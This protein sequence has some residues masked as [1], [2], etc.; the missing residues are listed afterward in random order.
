MGKKTFLLF[1]VLVLCLVIISCSS[2]LYAEQT[3]LLA[4]EDSSLK[5]VGAFMIKLNAERLADKLRSEGFEV[6]IR[7]DITQDNRA[8]YRVFAGEKQ[9]PS[10]V[11]RPSSAPDQV[12]A[13]MIKLNAERLADKLRSEGFEVEIREGIT[14]DNRAI[15]RVFAKESS[16]PTSEIASAEMVR[17]ETLPEHL[18]LTEEPAEAGEVLEKPDAVSKEALSS[19]ERK[20]VAAFK[21]FRSKNDAEA[22][23]QELREDGFKVEIHEPQTKDR[24]GLFT[25]F[26]EKPLEKLEMPE[27]FVAGKEAIK[28]DAVLEEEIPAAVVKPSEE[29]YKPAAVAEI[30]TTTAE[31]TSAAASAETIQQ[32]N[33]PEHMPPAKEQSEAEEVLEKPDTLSQDTLSSQKGRQIAAYKN[34][35][36][37]KDAEA[38]AEELREKGF[39]VETREIQTKDNGAIYTVFAKVPRMEVAIPEYSVKGQEAHKREVISDRERPA[40][41]VKPAEETREPVEVAAVATE[42][43]LKASEEMIHVE[44]TPAAV[45]KP[46]EETRETVEI[47]AVAAEED[48]KTAEA[49]GSREEGPV[50]QQRSGEEMKEPS[51]P[52]VLYSEIPQEETPPEEPAMEIETTEKERVTAADVY[53]KRGGYLHPFLSITGYYTDNVFNTPDNEDSDFVTVLSPGI[54]LSVPRIKQKLVNI[55]TSTIAPGGYK[56]SRS[57]ESFFR[58]YQVYLLYAA[59]FELF[60]KYHSE[61]FF[62]HR[63]EGL[64]QYN[65]RGGLTFE[66][67]DQFLYSHDIRG[68]GISDE[69]DK[70]YSNLA[71]VRLRFDPGRKLWFMADYANFVVDY[72]DPINDFRHRNDHALSGYVFYKLQPKTSAFFQ[73]QYIDVNYTN[74][75]LSNS[76]EHNMYGGLAWDITAK[77]Q[78]SIKAGYGTKDFADPSIKN[79]DNFILEAQLNHKFTPKTSVTLNAWR[80]TFETN[81]STTDYIL[82]HGIEFGY[83]QQFTGRLMGNVRLSYIND[84]YKGDLTYDGVT[85]ERKDDYYTGTIGLYYKFM[86]WLAS[87]IG[88]TYT[89]RNSNFPE[90]EYTNN[91]FFFNLTGSL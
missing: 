51:Q 17:Q 22:F 54:W 60:S 57:S 43:E 7:E 33:L 79:A 70:Y 35:R 29:S 44:E 40:A 14:Q 67:V 90:F 4:K 83:N 26:A 61:N 85:K 13:F 64:F 84:L 72:R 63:I 28:T 68:T 16:K 12:G 25:V 62:G 58:R 73:Y 80:R 74:D 10:D 15:Y 76:E 66:F 19:Q 56:V 75:I 71:N 77:S 53:G 18:P 86:D 38:F 32:E 52:E 1:F 21:I 50:L 3:A 47:A 36:V 88:Y 34:F 11:N 81:I 48:F 89:R 6:E 31:S 30:S 45:V 27:S 24:G 41:V 39:H 91:M 46:S 9:E 5:Q 2:Q 55:N 42:E 8:I 78:G 65:F 49:V 23:A 87:G 20:Q 82:S 59:D 69:L 37:E